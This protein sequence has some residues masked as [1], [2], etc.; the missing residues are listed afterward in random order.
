MQRSFVAKSTVNFP[1]FELYVRIGDILVYNAVNDNSLT[2]YRGGAIV[3]TIRTTPISI[4]VLLKTKMVVEMAAPASKPVVATPPALSPAP[5]ATVKPKSTS[6]PKAKLVPKTLIVDPATIENKVTLPKDEVKQKPYKPDWK[7]NEQG[8]VVAPAMTEKEIKEVMSLKAH[9]PETS[10]NPEPLA[11][12]KVEQK[13]RKAE[14]VE[15]SIDD[16]ILKE[17]LGVKE[18][19]SL[20]DNAVRERLGITPIIPFLERK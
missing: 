9:I 16:P 4:A 12:P 1:D 2:I 17:R 8:N 3:K 15:V 10:A 19:E 14:P 20:L 7:V 11:P 13:R 6:A 18:D 5:K